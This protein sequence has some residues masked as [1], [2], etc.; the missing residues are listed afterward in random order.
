MDAVLETLKDGIMESDATSQQARDNIDT[1]VEAED[2]AEA[3]DFLRDV[4][5][6]KPF[7][8][9]QVNVAY[10]AITR[11]AELSEPGLNALA[12]YAT[13]EDL[14]SGAQ[15]LARE[16]LEDALAEETGAAED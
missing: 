9:R 6:A 11:L 5:D 7:Q 10:H 4:I 8:H 1:V 16:Q 15:S 2:P 12:E 3:V 14:H 13:S